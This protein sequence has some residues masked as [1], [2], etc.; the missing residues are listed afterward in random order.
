MKSIVLILLILTSYTISIYSYLK[1]PY[2][3]I[4]SYFFWLSSILLIFIY[5]AYKEK[6]GIKTFRFENI[7]FASFMNNQKL[8]IVIIILG[9]IVRFW[10]LNS[11]PILTHDEAKDT[12]LFPQKI[13]SGEIKDYFG[14]YAGINNNFFVLSSIPHL[15]VTD[16]VLKI[17]L[18]SALFGVFSVL[19]IY[20]LVTSISGQKSGLIAAF[21]LSVYHIHIHFSRTEFLNLFDSFYV[22]IILIAFSRLNKSWKIN[23]AI[24]LA[25]ILGFGLHFY[26]GLRAIILLTAITFIIFTF[27]KLSFK[28]F[29]I[30]I[31]TFFAF[32]LISF[33]PTIIVII[34]R[35]EEF[36]ATGTATLTTSTNHTI[37]STINQIA[38]NYKDSILSYV[39]KPIDFHYN[40]GGPFLTIPFSILFL[41][42]FFLASKKIKEPIYFLIIISIL[43]IPF[44]NSAILNTI[45]YTHR[46][47]SLIP[48][49]IILTT[50]GINEIAKFLKYFTNDRVVFLF[51]IAICIYFAYY[52]INLYF[53]KNV[54]ENTLNIN[55][56]RAWE[57]QKIINKKNK[58]NTIT[59]FIGNDYFPSYKS[60]PPLEYLT[61]KKKVFDILNQD[62]FHQIF[63]SENFNSYLLIILPNNNAIIDQQFLNRYLSSSSN[64]FKKVYYK[65]L[66]LFDLLETTKSNKN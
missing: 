25:T 12:G 59:L 19:L 13:I 15:I 35:S 39:Q 2:D 58:E 33:G 9:I 50:F 62:T 30:F 36:K 6:V 23:N 24:I 21:F 47:M 44:F 29:S 51:T 4:Y 57:A 40:Y 17:R 26:S 41:L 42:G 66:Y 31:L 53:Y 28:K 20:L 18:F 38:I 37:N 14:F 46:L 22:L 1:H 48:L 63:D 11:I 49:I 65:N 52:N 43:G 10:N 34:T 61:Q 54:W 3:S 27:I 56:F 45:N 5:V 60:V 8:I 64:Y 7:P 55:E 16:P 32:L